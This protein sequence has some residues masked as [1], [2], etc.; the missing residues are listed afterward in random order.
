MYFLTPLCTVLWTRM[1]LSIKRCTNNHKARNLILYYVSISGRGSLYKGVARFTR[2]WLVASVPTRWKC[3]SR[4]KLWKS[5][6]SSFDIKK[7]WKHLVHHHLGKYLL[8][9]NNRL[10]RNATDRILQIL[11]L[12]RY[13]Q[14]SECI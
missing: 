5:I 12:L 14:V 7:K 2:V 1:N 13:Q 6:V 10:K 8:P 3:G 4:T 11:L 9:V